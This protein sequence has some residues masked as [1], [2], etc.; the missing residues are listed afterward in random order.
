MEFWIDS[1]DPRTVARFEKLGLLTGVTTNPELLSHVPSIDKTLHEL[2]DVTKGFLAVQVVARNAEEMVAQGKVINDLSDQMII[3][4]P[5]IP[6]GLAAIHELSKANIR[7]MATAIF[8]P[9]QALIAAKA[10]AD[11]VAPYLS[12]IQKAGTPIEEFLKTTSRIFHNYQLPTKI[13]AASINDLKQVE[14]CAEYSID[15]VTLTEPIFDKLV[16]EHALTLE[17]IR[18]FERAWK[19]ESAELFKVKTII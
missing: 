9:Q 10:G 4:V 7:T 6:E 16:E 3:K 13:I 12:R 14:L 15:A 1:A 19:A 2:L 18:Q 5:V 8:T 17:A 11:Y